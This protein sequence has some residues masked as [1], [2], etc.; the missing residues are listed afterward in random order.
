LDVQDADGDLAEARL[1]FSDDSKD[2]LEWDE[3]SLTIK[4]TDLAL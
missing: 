2:W 1:T 3:P 4:T